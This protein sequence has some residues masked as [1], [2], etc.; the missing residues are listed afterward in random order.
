MFLAFIACLQATPVATA[1]LERDITQ[2]VINH[3]DYDERIAAACTDVCGNKGWSRLDRVSVAPKAAAGYQVTV[4]ASAS[5]HQVASAADLFGGVFGEG[6][7]VEYPMQFTVVGDLDARDCVIRVTDVRVTGDTLGLVA[8]L[9]DI[10]GNRYK[11]PD[12]HSLL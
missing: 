9:A 6:L 1:P 10:K 2:L 8:G 7:D 11:V 5:Y 12:C 4:R 3:T